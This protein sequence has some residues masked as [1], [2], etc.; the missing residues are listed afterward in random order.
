[1]LKKTVIEL[2]LSGRLWERYFWVSH[3]ISAFPCPFLFSILVSKLGHK[4][5]Y[6]LDREWMWKRGYMLLTVVAKC[7]ILQKE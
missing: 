4:Q 6:G 5:G 1:L 2:S 7:S 3:S